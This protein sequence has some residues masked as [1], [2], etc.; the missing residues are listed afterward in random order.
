MSRGCVFIV[1]LRRLQLPSRTKQG[2]FEVDKEIKVTQTA[3]IKEVTARHLESS[4][5]C[6]ARNDFGNRSVTI[7]LK[8]RNTGTVLFPYKSWKLCCKSES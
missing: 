5:T 4:Y 3:V 6:F 2:A 7:R 1:N 8:K